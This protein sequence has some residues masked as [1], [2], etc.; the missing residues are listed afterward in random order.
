MPAKIVYERFLWFHKQVKAEKFPNAR[1]LAEKFELS[2]KATKQNF[3]D[4]FAFKLCP[5]KLL[6]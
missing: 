5:F 1:I 3:Y 2:Q 4:I 6:I